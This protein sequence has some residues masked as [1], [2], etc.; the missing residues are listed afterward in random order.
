MAAIVEFSDSA[1]RSLEDGVPVAHPDGQLRGQVEKE[2]GWVRDMD[3]RRS[4]LALAGGRDLAAELIGQQLHAVANPQDRHAGVEG[5]RIAAR[6]ALLVDAGRAA[7]EDQGAGLSITDRVPRRRAGDQL[8]VNA[9]FA[10]AARDQL[11]VLR[12]KVQ[13]QHEFLGPGRTRE[14]VWLEGRRAGDR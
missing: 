13:H 8:A 14:R 1:S 2:A 9:G 4:V 3:A 7:G 11:A 6:R 5:G 10:H 12:T